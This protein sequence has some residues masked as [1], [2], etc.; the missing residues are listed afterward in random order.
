M[1]GVPAIMQEGWLQEGQGSLG[2]RVGRSTPRRRGALVKEEVAVGR[3]A[4][5]VRQ[6]ADA[7][8]YAL[9]RVT[10]SLVRGQALLP[11]ARLG[12]GSPLAADGMAQSP[13]LL[14]GR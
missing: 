2:R 6:H 5:G 10:R 7:G 8:V 1:R 13:H 11:R 14:R 3:L 4:H 9:A 12:P